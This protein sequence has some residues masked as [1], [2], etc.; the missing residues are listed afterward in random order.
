MKNLSII[1]LALI[2]ISCNSEKKNQA[3]SITDLADIK[4]GENSFT[5][6]KSCD[7]RLDRI[8]TD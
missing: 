4:Q 8:K 1:L 5:S 3:A 7:R 6:A 2:A